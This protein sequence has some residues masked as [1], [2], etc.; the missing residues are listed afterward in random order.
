MCEK[1]KFYSLSTFQLHNIVLSTAVIRKEHGSF[2]KKDFIY[3]FEREQARVEG[4]EGE[5]EVDT[6]L[7]REPNVRLDPRT[8]RS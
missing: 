1:C 4:A 6:F 2:F 8:L 3:L 5:G 7:S